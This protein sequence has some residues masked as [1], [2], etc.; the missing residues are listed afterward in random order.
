MEGHLAGTGD[1][2]VTRVLLGTFM[3][4]PVLGQ[5][6]VL[7]DALIDLSE[8][9]AIVRVR[10]PGDDGYAETL[11]GDIE[12][13]PKGAY[14]LPGFCDLH[15]HAPQ[16]PQLGKALDVP[17]EVWLQQYTFPLEARYAD[18][19]FAER[20]YSS[21]VDGLL[22]NGTTTALYF[23]TQHQA[24]TRRLAEICLEKGQRALI[25]KVVMDNAEQCPSFYCE[26][27]EDGLR[28]TADFIAFVNSHA[29][30]RA[31][32]V[33]PVITPRFIPSCT[34]EALKGLG[35]LAKSC[36]CHVQTHCSESDWQHAYVLD[37]HGVSDTE[38]L[39]RFGLL[40]RHT[41]LAHANFISGADMDTIQARGAGVA[42]CPLS[43]HYFSNAVFPLRRALE[44]GVRVGLGTDISGGPSA[45]LFDNIRWAVA[46]S[47]ALDDGVDSALPYERRGVR[48]SAVDWKTAFYLA[49]K[50]G[51]DVLDLPVGAFEPGRAF[52]A[53]L[54]DP[55]AKGG[56]VTV[57]DGL[58]T[59]EDV[60]QKIVYTASKANIAKVWIS[61]RTVGGEA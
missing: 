34:D 7:E 18:V 24:A 22:A 12:R 27:T 15:V 52:D 31:G 41:V 46:S 33:K 45:S 53:I 42:H 9:G 11:K 14:V 57:F 5:V 55:Q 56:T 8:E 40:T 39:D 48:N 58:D 26:T 38:S 19:T 25:G 16:W 37:R 21:L 13:M 50:G 1:C 61:G 60:F 32:R 49:T 17:L 51:A 2:P 47:R 23:A 10:K 30:N 36:G 29:G 4:T 54:I 6:E 28:G 44:K 20:A 43:N 3:H 59:P 35:A